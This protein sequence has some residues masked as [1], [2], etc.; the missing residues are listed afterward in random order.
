MRYREK[1]WVYSF[2]FLSF[3]VF[4]W[5]SFRPLQDQISATQKRIQVPS[6]C[7]HHERLVATSLS[8]PQWNAIS[9]YSRLLLFPSPRCTLFLPWS[10]CIPP[11]SSS[12]LFSF[13]FSYVQ[14][15]YLIPH[16][17]SSTIQHSERAEHTIFFP[18]YALHV[19]MSID[20]QAVSLSSSFSCPTSHPD[21]TP[22]SLL[23]TNF[24]LCCWREPLTTLHIHITMLNKIP[25]AS[26]S[27]ALSYVSLQLH[28]QGDLLLIVACTGHT[29]GRWFGEDRRVIKMRNPISTIQEWNEAWTL[30][31]SSLVVKLA[32]L[33][34]ALL[35]HWLKL[36]KPLL[37]VPSP[38]RRWIWEVHRWIENY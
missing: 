30:F 26:K 8:S 28:H 16:L 25:T 11:L 17:S 3:S 29:V 34:G 32:E 20:P 10:P 38:S 37:S 13:P 19:A 1:L 33:N 23:W 2:S 27:R 14:L 31:L 4:F 22:Q 9:G 12:P 24:A 7:I 36:T 15:L 5:S 6:Q 18:A 35:S 21:C